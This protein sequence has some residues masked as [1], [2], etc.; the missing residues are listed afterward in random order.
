MVVRFIITASLC[1]LGAVVSANTRP[2]ALAASLTDAPL[3]QRLLACTPTNTDKLDFVIAHRG[4]PLG[5]PEHSEQGYRAAAAQGAG[6][7]ECDVT[8]TQ[9]GQFVCRHSQCDLHRTT[10]ILATP[11]AQQCSNPFTPA[12]SD[13]PAGAQCCTSDI[14]LAQYRSLCARPD[15]VNPA[16]RTVD[17][18]LQARE[19]IVG[20]PSPTCGTLMTLDEQIALNTSLNVKHVPELKAAMVPMP[21]E[22]MTQADYADRLIQ[23]YLEAGV[24]LKLL[25]PQSFSL[26]D[27]LYWINAYPAIANQVIYLD[28][29]GRARDFQP[30]LDGM[31]ALYDQGVRILAPPIPVLITLNEQREIVPSPYAELARAV[32]FELITWTLESRSAADPMNFLYATV[33]EAIETEGDLYKVLDVLTHQVGIRAIFTDW[34]ETAHF[35]AQCTEVSQR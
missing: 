10:N 7:V 25:Y 12:V 33:R 15:H 17:D 21:Y 23:S 18:Y 34:P 32:G 16:A 35:F 11:I 29:R 3:K 8:F 30:S 26:D 27:V 20:T 14:T 6:W 1:L 24:D 28:P 2:L 13:A 9:D 19:S 22:G 4:A 5:Y 31:Q